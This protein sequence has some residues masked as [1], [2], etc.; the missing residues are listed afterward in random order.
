MI[1]EGVSSVAFKAFGRGV[2]FNFQGLWKGVSSIAVMSFEGRG[3]L[4]FHEF[5]KEC[6]V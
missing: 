3:E 1:Y 4:R 2:D 6:L 5:W